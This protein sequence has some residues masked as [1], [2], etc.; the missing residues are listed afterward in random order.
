MGRGLTV[1]RSIVTILFEI[2]ILNGQPAACKSIELLATLLYIDKELDTTL[3]PFIF[4]KRANDHKFN[5]HD[6]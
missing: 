6:S 4:L 2:K 5:D 3:V 1:I